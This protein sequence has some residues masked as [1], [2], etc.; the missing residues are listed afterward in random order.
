ML[1]LLVLALALAFPLVPLGENT[2]TV[3]SIAVNI[4]PVATLALSWDILARTGQLSLAHAAFFGIGGYAYAMLATA[5]L[6]ALPAALAGGLSAAVVSLGLGA[7]TLRLHGMYFAIATLAFTEVVRTLVNQAPVSLTGGPQ[8][9]LAPGIAPDTTGQWYVGVGIL[10]LA[11]AASLLV[12]RSRL[13]AA[14]A[15]IRQGEIVA[16]VL[17]VNATRYKLVAFAISSLLAGLAGAFVAG[18]TF[19]LTPPDTFS[20]GWSVIA[21]VVPIFG[22][23]YTT[24]GPVL[25]AVILRSLEEVLKGLSPQGYLVVY[26]AILVLSILYLPR[27]LM[28]LL[29]GARRT[30]RAVNRRGR[31]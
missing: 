4:L 7:V 18:K 30:P 20:V 8:G 27:G 23:L 9:L 15:A 29:A 21:L 25:A 3:R 5:G 24:A 2:A 10:T 31:A 16:R 22:G 19:F 12:D 1:G 17:G 13:G 28:G 11:V 14:F 26:G 6:P